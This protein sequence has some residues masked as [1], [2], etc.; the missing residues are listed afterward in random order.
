MVAV[1]GSVLTGGRY[2]VT[3]CHQCVDSLH[4]TDP[5]GEAAG[6]C[7]DQMAPLHIFLVHFNISL[8][9]RLH[10]HSCILHS[11]FSMKT[12]YL[13]PFASKHAVCPTHPALLDILTVQYILANPD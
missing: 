2:A 5:S 11:G 4:G 3:R 13:F 8:P 1:M 9:L 10:I 12:L 6:Q 7:A